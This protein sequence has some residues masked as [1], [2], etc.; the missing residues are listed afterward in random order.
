MLVNGTVTVGET[1]TIQG[2]DAIMIEGTMDAG[3]NINNAAS[4][5]LI[6]GTLS[7]SIKTS[8]AVAYVGSDV[9]NAK[10]N[11]VGDSSDA[12]ITKYYVNGSE[13]A[14]VY[15]TTG[16]D[17]AAITLFA[18]IPG[19]DVDTAQFYS[20]AEMTN[21]IANMTKFNAAYKTTPTLN[22][23]TLIG[24]FGNSKTVGSYEN[25]YVEMQ[26]SEVTGTITIYNGMSLYIDGIKY[27]N[28]DK[29]TL[30]V[31]EHKFSV[32]VEPGLTG[33]PVITLDGQTVTSSF[34]IADNAKSF[35]LVVTG[36]IAYDTGSTDDGG[37]GLTEILLIIL[38]VLIVIMA[39]MVALRLM[40]S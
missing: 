37:M 14:T 25:V 39:I 16:I 22:L 23:S 24:Y 35:Q 30:T 15:A 5:I 26:P 20:D 3:D 10:I 7:G 8:A 21:E 34:T 12:E 32:Q 33:T 11:Y 38:V 2:M 31:G 29:A 9:S 18:D 28:S 1:G 17:I 40:R 13:Y 27:N 4:V 6:N 36:E 19:V